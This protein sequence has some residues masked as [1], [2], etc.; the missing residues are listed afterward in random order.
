MMHIFLVL[1]ETWESV[2]SLCMCVHMILKRIR[3]KYGNIDG[4]IA[5]EHCVC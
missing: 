2:F 4:V 5:F 3:E 1:C